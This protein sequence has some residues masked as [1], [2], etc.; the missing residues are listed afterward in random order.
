MKALKVTRNKVSYIKGYQFQV[1]T[2]DFKGDTVT[3]TLKDSK[4]EYF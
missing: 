1:A 3:A 2:D 4:Y